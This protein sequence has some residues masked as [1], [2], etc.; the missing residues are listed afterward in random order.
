MS[1]N[2]DS[3]SSR[4]NSN[5]SRLDVA[6]HPSK[7]V[8]FSSLHEFLE[9]YLLLI[10]T[11]NFEEEEVKN[12]GKECV[13]LYTGTLNS[14]FKWVKRGITSYIEE[15]SLSNNGYLNSIKNLQE[16]QSTVFKSE[17]AGLEDRFKEDLS[18]IESTFPPSVAELFHERISAVISNGSNEVNQCYDEKIDKLLEQ[19]LTYFFISTLDS[20]PNLHSD[21]SGFPHKQMTQFFI[22][23]MA[24]F[25]DS[26]DDLD[27]ECKGALLS[28]S[29]M[30]K[31]A[32]DF[33]NLRDDKLLMVFK[34][35]E[36]KDKNPFQD[37][38]K[39]VE[40]EIKKLGIGQ[41]MVF[42]GGTEGHGVVFE[43][44]RNSDSNYSFTIIN[45]GDDESGYYN[46]QRTD[47]LGILFA[48]NNHY[49]HKSYLVDSATLNAGFLTRLINAKALRGSMGAVVSLIDQY[50]IANGAKPQ[51]GRLHQPQNRGSCAAKANSSWLKG[52]LIRQLGKEK[53]ISLY[54]QFKCFRATKN[55]NAV[56]RL[57]NEVPKEHFKNALGHRTYKPKKSR[58]EEK[59]LLQKTPASELELSKSLKEMH[60]V[61]EGVIS[62][63]S[64]KA[65][66]AQL[67][68]P[69][70]E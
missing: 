64:A 30:L 69:T 66:A 7:N 4:T 37:V 5:S 60:L 55:L 9:K 51:L 44:I 11:G 70:T 10:E 28:C 27:D 6:N 49:A 50:F 41:S 61:A 43:V 38:A 40:S 13:E 63:W 62:R 32:C 65:K 34:N 58:Y 47:F 57:E 17:V 53:G 42:L 36:E 48:D 25:L 16:L 23:D 24:E 19:A 33:A 15:K 67:K 56:L 59:V 20:V 3:N 39:A 8:L 18:K 45:T 1:L 29:S 26:Q 12:L 54:L 2:V 21:L 31:K 68:A 46:R 35:P 14:Y 52:E 22:Q